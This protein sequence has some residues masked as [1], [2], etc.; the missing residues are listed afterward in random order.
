MKDP[1]GTMGTETIFVMDSAFGKNVLKEFENME[2]FKAGVTRK[3]YALPYQWDGTGGV[4]YGQ[5][6]YYNRYIWLSCRY[7]FH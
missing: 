2:K 7:F 5:Y 1:L 3:T 4:V 6:L